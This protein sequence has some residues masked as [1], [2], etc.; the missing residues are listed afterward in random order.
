MFPDADKVCRNLSNEHLA[1]FG[2]V[3]AVVDMLHDVIDVHCNIQKGRQRAVA[4][5]FGLP[6]LKTFTLPTA[7]TEIWL[8]LP[9]GLFVGGFLGPLFPSSLGCV[10]VLL[11]QPLDMSSLFQGRLSTHHRT[12]SLCRGGLT[13][14]HPFKICHHVLH[15]VIKFDATPSDRWYPALGVP[16]FALKCAEQIAELRGLETGVVLAAVRQNVSQL[17]RIDLP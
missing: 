3:D 17:Y 10:V 16:G 1:I 14:Q 4:E 8:W 13:T 15:V 6:L 7:V 5:R 12:Q 11:G 9:A 2:M